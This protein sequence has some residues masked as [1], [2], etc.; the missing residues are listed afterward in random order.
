[1]VGT[2]FGYARISDVTLTALEDSGWYDVDHSRAEPLE[3]GDYRAI[4]G[5][6]IEDF[7]DFAIGPPAK[8]WPDHY[9]VKTDEV[10]QYA[11]PPGSESAM[12]G[13]T[14]DYRATG[15][16]APKQRNC[17]NG[18]SKNECAYPKFYDANNLGV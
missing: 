2:T 12:P 17:E 11:D 5:A 3:W 10:K 8:S 7:K 16:V 15:W 1:M 13:C 6:T 18:N 9:V 4:V 14:F